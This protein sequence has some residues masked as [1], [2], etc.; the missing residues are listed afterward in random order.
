LHD[1]LDGTDRGAGYGAAVLE[2][3]GDRDVEVTAITHDSRAAGPGAL[4]C[5]IPGARADGHDFAPAAARA[6]AVACLVERFVDV[7]VPQARVASVRAA[8][9][10]LSACFFGRPS[11]SMRV[12]GVTGTNGKTTL[13]YLLERITTAAGGRS[14]IIGT[15]GARIGA[16]PVPL[17]HTTPEATELQELLARMRDDG[18]T[19]VAME[20]SSHALDQRRVD[21]TTF[22]AACFTNLTHDHLDYHGTID[23]YFAAKARLFTTSF[24]SRAAVNL[25][26]ERGARLAG[27][28][29]AGGVD[30][31]TYAVDAPADVRSTEVVLDAHG[32]RCAIVHPEG[33]VEVRLPLAGRFNV[34]N[35][36][37]AFATARLGGIPADVVAEAFEQPLTVPGRMERVDLGQPFAVLVDYAHT[38]VAL[39]AVLDAARALLRP[40]GRLLVVFGCGGDRDRAKRPVMGAV[41]A[42]RADVAFL[43]S[44]NPRSEDPAE[45]ARDVLAGV[46]DAA[47]P[48]VELDRRAAIRLALRSAAPGDVVVIA[49]KGH[50]SGQTAGG[51]TVPFDDRVVAREE[52]EAGA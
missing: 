36:T 16:T 40:A 28:A 6:G 33:R 48:I 5:C 30:V 41:A 52:L 49:G 26:D 1:L 2:M 37:A 31:C 4:F 46:G 27:I 47:P 10:P 12:F 50:E 29:R 9:G 35:L 23:D 13:T 39:A 17:P 14:G 22:T 42:R 11:R 15:T 3:R 43:T 20:V 38:P 21:G 32:G 44:D 19:D 51:V 18:V 8:I 45:I 24:T 34:V 7:P 25:D